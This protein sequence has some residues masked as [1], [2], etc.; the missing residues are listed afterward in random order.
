MGRAIPLRD[1]YDGPTLRRLAKRS[2]DAGQSR[3]LLA[4]S[5]I[6][7]GDRRTDAARIGC[8]GLQVIRD[9]VIGF[10]TGGPEGL[11]GRKSSGRTPKL[12]ARHRQS[13]Y[14]LV[15]QGPIPAIHG[16]VRWRLKDL[17][18][19]LQE[20]Y[21]VSVSE[22]TVSRELKALGFSKITA[23]PRHN[24]QNE[25]AIEDFKKTFPPHWKRFAPGSR[26]A[27]Q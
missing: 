6:Y 7:D 25:F 22:S 24:G 11:I 14:D 8:V 9:W 20:E 15:E 27:H 10:N 13:L 1:D 2:K 16:V 3:R 17:A 5:V 19:W 4:L 12:D 18:L 21:G 26:L 23:R